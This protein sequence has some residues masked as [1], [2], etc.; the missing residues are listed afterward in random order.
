MALVERAPQLAALSEYLE[1]T[2]DGTGV[3]ALV[4]G[5]AGAGKSALVSAFLS[6]IAVPIAAGVCDGVATPRP[7]GPVIEIAAQLE[8]DTTMPRDE[9]FAGIVAALSRPATVVLLEDLHW[10]DDASADFVL[11]AGRRLDRVPAVLIVTYRDDEI[12]SNARLTRV[13]GEL[14]R[15][16]TARRVPVPPL[17]RSGVASLV[18][19]SGLD[20]SEVFEQTAGNAF[21]VSEMVA[22]RSSQPATVREAVLSRAARLTAAGRRV[23]DIASQL[24]VR[25]DASV[26]VEASGPDAAGVDDSIECGLLTSCA[27]EL[28]FRHELARVTIADELA[29][30][31]RATVNRAILRALESRAGV[32][33]SRLA[34]H[35][36]A[37]HE[38]DAAFRY[39]VEAGNRAAELGSHGEAVHH[40][41]TA[42]R[43]ASARPDRERAGL[44]DRLAAECMVTDQMD[45]ALVAA[46]EALCAWQAIGDPIRIGAAHMSLDHVYWYLARGDEAQAHAA[47]AVAVLEP[48]GPSV[49]LARALSGMAAFDVELGR[50]E[51]AIASGRRAL[52]TATLVEDAAAESDVLNSIGSALAWTGQLEEGITYLERSLQIALDSGNGHLA[53]RAYA[54]L[55]SALADYSRFARSDAVLAE[56][57][58]YTEDHELTTRFMCLTGILAETEVARGRWDDAVADAL[59]VLDRAG[60]ISIG[61]LPA[62]TVLGTIKIRRGDPDG[63]AMLVDALRVAESCGEFQRVAPLTTALAEEA[64]LADDTATARRLLGSLLD[65]SRDTTH[66]RE[67]G[68]LLSWATRLGDREPAPPG[69]PPELVLEIEGRWDEAARMWDELGHPY[70]RAM[71]LIQVGTAEALN[72]AFGILDQLGARPVAAVAAARL[73]ALGERVPRGPRHTTRAN[74]AGLTAREVEVLRLV[75]DGLTNPEIAARLFISD[76]TVEHHVS[77]ILGKLDVPSRRDAARAARDLDIAP[78]PDEPPAAASPA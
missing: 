21:F 63:H 47:A 26:L 51:L 23:L 17:T 49:E 50:P 15:L 57:L 18:D 64:W 37:A 68:R 16:S 6:D 74:P 55:A 24:G 60:S 5:E 8:V 44:Y 19:G 25:F 20:P 62:L 27:D 76:K 38:A 22:A 11:Y 1:D 12:G 58:Q 3:L 69:T 48:L 54:N 72:E 66:P 10:A 77:R 33:V 34:T 73:R 46:E 56:G 35:A 29:P 53:G 36:A 43:F 13:V 52:E 67:V 61:R 42:L 31:R 70:A 45:D 41:R 7:L 9:L 59:G 78:A 65:R 30:V 75:A 2:R 40:Y 32:D 28:C 39:G 4:G 14:A 71:A